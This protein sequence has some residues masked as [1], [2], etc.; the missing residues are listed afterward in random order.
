MLGSNDGVNFKIVAG[1]ETQREC[2]DLQFPYYP[3]QSYRYFLF[4]VVGEL[5]CNSLI[6]GFELEIAPAWNNRIN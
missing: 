4:A 1:S 2:C 6:T 3:S 5:G